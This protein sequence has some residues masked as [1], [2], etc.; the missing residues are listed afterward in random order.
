M[1]EDLCSLEKANAASEI[2][3]YLLENPGATD[4]IEGIADWWLIERKIK[5]HLRLV[6]TVLADLVKEELIIEYEG[7]YSKNHFKINCNKKKQ[8]RDILNGNNG[9]VP[10]G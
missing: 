3:E 1:M 4:T 10:S 2:L 9:A 6:K 8:I 7:R 5:Y